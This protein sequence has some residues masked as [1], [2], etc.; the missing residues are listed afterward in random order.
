MV[1]VKTTKEIIGRMIEIQREKANMTQQQLAYLLDV[2]RQYVWRLENGKINITANYLDKVIKHL[3][4][5]HADFLN[6]PVVKET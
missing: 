5:R 4:C 6:L 2:D 1:P 3:N